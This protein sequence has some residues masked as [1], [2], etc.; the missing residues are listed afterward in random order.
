VKKPAVG[1]TKVLK[2]ISELFAEDL[3]ARRVD[4]LA[5]ATTGVMKAGA[6][7]VY[8]I[9][10]ALA[11]V[12]GLNAKHAVKQVD[13]LMS[14]A[15]IVVEHL[16]ARWVPFVVASRD[17]LLVAL[18]WTDFEA[19]DQ[20]TLALHLVTSHGRTTP[21]LWKTV[22]KSELKGQQTQHED[23]MLRRLRELVPE[24]VRV[25][26]LAD[27]GFA[28]QALYALL[29][30]LRLDFVIR[31]RDAIRVESAEGESKP[32]REWVPAN[33]RPK[34]LRGATV[35]ADRTPVAA[36]VCVRGK[37]MKEGWCLASS[38][39]DAPASVIV[40]LYAKRFT[41]EESFRDLKDP[42]F[43]FGLSDTR[44]SK[45]ERRDRMLLIGALATTLL[46]LLG[47]AGEETGI[48]RTLKVNT[49]KKRAYSL[50]RQGR[51]LYEM[52]PNMPAQRA[53]PLVAAFS[54]RVAELPM[55]QEVLA[56]I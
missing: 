4:S 33:G 56:E 19:D 42:R 39:G 52:L 1:H 10:Q 32:A 54:R 6:L 50:L 41:I 28:D 29:G 49:S 25:T 11:V 27:R 51:M 35:T 8:A 44:I 26:V 46:T 15:G 37:A 38:L 22:V 48:D 34:L 13:R 45:P 30:E 17:E 53:R 36:V 23:A 47:A 18:D 31:F 55:I 14:N 9:G 5:D 7:G 43:G 12:K 20:V 16:L 21:L 24:C 2:V 3:H 40:A